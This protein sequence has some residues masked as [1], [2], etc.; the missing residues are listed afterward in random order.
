MISTGLIDDLIAVVQ[1]EAGRA[2]IAARG[3]AI[4]AVSI[5]LASLLLVLALVFLSV[6]T[7][8]T[9]SIAYGTLVA[10]ALVGGGL[11][12]VALM[13]ILFAMLLA[14]RKAR[15]K[16][17]AQA[18]LA[19]AAL[20]GDMA[21]VMCGVRA[22]DLSPVAIGL[23]ALAAGVVAGLA[24]AQTTD[25]PETADNTQPQPGSSG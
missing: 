15:R 10:G 5:G 6:G 7:Y 23:A 22:L 21:R 17:E 9:L 24:S 18:T 13:I 14:N 12:I 3:T 2:R 8:S 1:A 16:A 19:R 20:S 25:Q 4:R 11:S